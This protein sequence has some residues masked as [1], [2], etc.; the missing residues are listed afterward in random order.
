MRSF[1]NFTACGE[2]RTRLSVENAKSL[3]WYRFSTRR[4]GTKSNLEEDED[5][6][7]PSDDDASSPDL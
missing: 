5:E 3:T 1:L 4:S 2:R 7:I 6:A